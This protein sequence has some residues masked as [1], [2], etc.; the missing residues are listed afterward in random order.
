MNL[1]VAAFLAA[2][3]LFLLGWNVGPG[4]L[5]Y[6]GSAA[7]IVA[8]FALVAYHD[9]LRAAIE[10]NR[11]MSQINQQGIA[12]LKR[13]W[14][15][16]WERRVVVPP[17]HEA[18]AADLDL[19]GHASLFQLLCTAQTPIGIRTL[20]DWLLEPASPDEVKRRQQAAAEL[21]PCLELRQATILEGCLLA[22]GGRK[23]E[24][25]AE[26]AE[27]GPWL[28]ARPTLLWTVRS[29]AAAAILIPV[30]TACNVVSV[31]MGFVAMVVVVLINAVVTATYG[32]RLHDI[33]ASVTLRRSGAARYLRLFKLLYSMP[34]AAVELKAIKSGATEVGGGVLRRLAQLNRIAWLANVC[35]SPMLKYLVYL[36]LQLGL[37]YDFHML[38]LLEAWQARFGR[39]VREWFAA[40]GKFEALAS[41][42]GL[43]YDNPPWVLPDVSRSA[44]RFDA[45]SLGHPLLPCE[46]RVDNDVEVGPA[47]SFLLVSGSNMSGKSTLLRAVGLNAVLAEAGGPVCAGQMT[48]PPAVLA[49]SM[50]VR[51]SLA[52]GV[53]FYMAELMRL[54]EIVD[55]ARDGRARNDRP[56]LYLLDEILLGTNS[57]ERHLAVVRVVHFLVRCDAIGAISTHDLDLATSEV[58]ANAC[59]CVHFRET[60]H[61]RDAPRP[62]TFDYRLRPGVATTSNALKMLEIVGLGEDGAA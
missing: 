54:K 56:V 62:M 23:M 21:A 39:H 52:D 34:D 31:D 19:F 58:L 27:G 15:A 55:L 33:F 17:A 3:G 47:G 60:L 35:R 42:A 32:A 1:R 46:L 43:V 7:A 51:D 2:A 29:L 53:S 14:N 8:F 57:R 61:G 20:R 36:P 49:T 50:R 26:W 24:G 48:M 13:D 45:R 6:P 5:W 37:L 11:L 40:L 4:R 30:A 12:R 22:D 18:T 9:A 38:S 10:R 16:L 25:F 28:A 59:R 41:L 44:D